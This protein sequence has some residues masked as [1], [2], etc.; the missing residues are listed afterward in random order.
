[1]RSVA[2]LLTLDA[3]LSFE[4]RNGVAIQF[5]A[6][7][8]RVSARRRAC[9]SLTRNRCGINDG[10]ICMLGRSGEGLQ[11]HREAELAELGDQA[12]GLRLGRAAVEVS[13]TEVLMLGALFSACGRSR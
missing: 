12:F 11:L 4:Q 7:L 10:F 2:E 5:L 1:M 3:N 8:P 9:W 13:G 6:W